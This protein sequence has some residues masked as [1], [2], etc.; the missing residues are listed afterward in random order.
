[1]FWHL[2][3]TSVFPGRSGD[4]E[5]KRGYSLEGDFNVAVI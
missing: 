5:N 4:F 3:Y 1:M 2:P